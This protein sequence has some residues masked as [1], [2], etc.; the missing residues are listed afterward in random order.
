MCKIGFLRHYEA[1]SYRYK[2]CYTTFYCPGYKPYD[3]IL[4]YWID[5]VSYAREVIKQI[6]EF[7][8]DV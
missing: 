2:G 5:D 3:S 4:N 7:I 8:E 6:I 1:H